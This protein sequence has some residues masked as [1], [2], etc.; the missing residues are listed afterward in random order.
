MRQQA[1][2][3]GHSPVLIALLMDHTDTAVFCGVLITDFAAV[4]FGT[5]IH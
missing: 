5:V 1:R 4:V 3:G 2:P